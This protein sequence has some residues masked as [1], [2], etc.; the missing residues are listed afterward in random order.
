MGRVFI[1]VPFDYS[2]FTRTEYERTRTQIDV[3]YLHYCFRDGVKITFVIQIC[4]L[5][6][7]SSRG[8]HET[9]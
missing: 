7:S 4:K 3:L 6:H 5:L 1:N 8:K 2:V 9:S